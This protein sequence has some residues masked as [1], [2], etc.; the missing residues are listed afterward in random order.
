[1]GQ[2]K[3]V[4]SEI[5]QDQKVH[6]CLQNQLK[7]KTSRYGLLLGVQRGKTTFFEMGVQKH[8]KN[9]SIEKSRM[10]A[11]SAVVDY[12]YEHNIL[13]YQAALWTKKGVDLTY[14]INTA[15]FSNFEHHKFGAG[16]VVGFRFVGFHL[17]TGYNFLVSTSPAAANTLNNVNNLYISLRYFIPTDVKYWK[18]DNSDKEKSKKKKSKEKEKSKKEKAKAKAKKKKLQEKGKWEPQTTGEKIEYFFN[19]KKYSEK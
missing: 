7:I 6:D 10:Y 17:T 14:G 2:A 9:I 11:L 5:Y 19:K 15:F 8:W 4:S 1:M 3:L 18:E 16:P 12:N 13:G